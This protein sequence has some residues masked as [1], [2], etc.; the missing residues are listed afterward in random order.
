MCSSHTEEL[1]YAHIKEER[2][3]LC[4]VI[5]P[6]HIIVQRLFA[7]ISVYIRCFSLL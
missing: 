2:N 6:M 7:V 1:T 4:T 3:I 5:S